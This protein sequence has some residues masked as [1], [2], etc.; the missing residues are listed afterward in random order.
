MTEIRFWNEADENISVNGLYIHRVDEALIE[1]YIQ[2]IGREAIENGAVSVT[3]DTEY[4]MKDLF[5]EEDEN[6]KICI[7]TNFVD[8]YEDETIE[9][10]YASNCYC[11]TYGHC[12]GYNCR[13][14][15][16][17]GGM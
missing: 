9:D 4:Q 17:C 13:Y 16:S 10:D 1:V 14:F 5:I 15:G 2:A 7:E 11:D 6:G 8:T 3:I 12:A